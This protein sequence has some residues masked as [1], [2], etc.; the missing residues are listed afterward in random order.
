MGRTRKRQKMRTRNKVLL[1]LGLFI[2]VFIIAMVVT[3]WVKDSVPEVLIDR[4]LQLCSIEGGLLAWLTSIERV[5]N[6]K[7]TKEETE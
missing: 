1:I 3:F 6:R 5:T 4:V 7:T 2:A